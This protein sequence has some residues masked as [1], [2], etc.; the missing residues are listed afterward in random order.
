[1]VQKVI[2]IRNWILQLFSSI[3]FIT[4]P[5]LFSYVTQL[6]PAVRAHLILLCIFN[7]LIIAFP[8]FGN[9]FSPSGTIFLF[10]Y[11]FILRKSSPELTSASNLSLFAEEDSPWANICAHHPLIYMW[12]TCHSMAWQALGRSTPGIRTSD[13]Q[14]RSGASELNC[15]APDWPP[16]GQSF[17]LFNQDAFMVFTVLNQYIVNGCRG[18]FC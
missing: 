2:I 6:L 17:H 11:L 8:P 4:F 15:C 16:Q 18:G 5:C 14:A 3:H 10:I 1:M 12:D 13:P 7:V 9:K